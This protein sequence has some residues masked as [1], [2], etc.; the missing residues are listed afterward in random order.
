VAKAGSGNVTAV[1]PVSA[2]PATPAGAELPAV[3]GQT[4]ADAPVAAAEVPRLIEEANGADAAKR[5]LAIAAL[6]RA[7]R[8]QALPALHHIVTNGEPQVDR[9]AALNSLRELALN[10]GD[11]D[12]KVRE[13]IREV[14][15]HDDGSN[16]QLASAAQ[17]ALDVVEESEMK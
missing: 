13:A 6:A 15:Y 16:P 8:D 4:E 7:P 10:Q 14:I 2:A 12:G 17:D 9:P 11:K 1:A 3:T 5:A